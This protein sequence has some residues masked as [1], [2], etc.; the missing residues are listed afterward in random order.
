M[1]T[2]GFKNQQKEK[3]FK[4]LEQG[5]CF[6]LAQPDS[7][8]N[9]Y[10]KMGNSIDLPSLATNIALQLFNGHITEFGAEDWIF[11]YDVNIMAN[12]AKS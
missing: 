9:L 10:M 2:I 4:D 12:E 11:E 5:A 3:Q 8:H 1:V 6:T 7:N